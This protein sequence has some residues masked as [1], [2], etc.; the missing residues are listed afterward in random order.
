MTEPYD[1]ELPLFLQHDGLM[2]GTALQATRDR[3]GLERITTVFGQQAWLV[4]CAADVRTV[5][6]NSA[7]FTTGDSVPMFRP[8]DPGKDDLPGAILFMD[9]PEHTMIRS[10]LTPSFT[11]RA[12]ARLEPRITEIVSEHLDAM[13]D[14]GAPADLV[15]SFSWPVP[16]QVIC[17]MLGIP[18]EDRKGFQGFVDASFDFTISEEERAA[19]NQGISEYIHRLADRAR[20]KPGSDLIGTLI[21]EQGDRLSSKNLAAIGATMLQA[22]HETTAEMMASSTFALLTHH[23]QL[24]LL[25]N[26][27]GLIRNAVD[28]LLRYLAI[29]QISAPR[30]ATRDT[31]VGG[32]DIARGD[33]LQ[34]SLPSANHDPA[35]I[36]DPERLDLTRE[37][38]SHLAFGHGIHYCLGAPLARLE[39]T[40]A[41]PALLRRFPDLALAVA[42]E[43]VEYKIGSVVH[44]VKALPVT[45]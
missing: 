21:R 4:A 5:L 39:M 26:D 6:G 12:L 20:D 1:Q 36:P 23:D 37:A 24:Q 33:L 28:E 40:I 17:E 18:L 14:A 42:P 32:Q 16:S 27:P 41:L 2:P 38:S 10:M 9:P 44:G 11:A 45:W 31:V 29:V 7:L 8:D 19:G 35:L 15:A 3:P 22:G 25:R 30:R 43:A 34:V 13:A